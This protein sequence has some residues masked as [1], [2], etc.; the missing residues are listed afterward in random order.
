MLSRLF[1]PQLQAQGFSAGQTAI[2]GLKR[3]QANRGLGG[4]R[5]ALTQEAGLRS[6]L[7]N[8]ALSRAFQGGLGLAGQRAGVWS[9]T[10]SQTQ[11]NMNMSNAFMQAIQQ[12]LLAH[13]LTGK[14]GQSANPYFMGTPQTSFGLPFNPS[15]ANGLY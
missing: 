10:P 15:Q 2:A 13:A 5:I 1:L 9:Q 8:D 14:Q 11:P 7:A 3:S 6:N 4:S 12:G